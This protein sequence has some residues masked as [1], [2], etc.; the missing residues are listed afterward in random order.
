M[1]LPLAAVPLRVESCR[2][3]RAPTRSKPESRRAAREAQTAS[4]KRRTTALPFAEFQKVRPAQNRQIVLDF[5]LATH[6]KYLKKFILLFRKLD[7]NTDGVLDE[8]QFRALLREMNCVRAEAEVVRLL[9]T[10]DPFNNQRITFSDCLA[11][12]SSVPVP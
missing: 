11:L 5:Q 10:V 2:K 6:E 12:L 8:A 7:T 4:L 1:S 3:A 9:E